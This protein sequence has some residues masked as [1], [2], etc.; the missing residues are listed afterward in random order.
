MFNRGYRG[1]G[2]VTAVST[3]M[4]LDTPFNLKRL[5]RSEKMVGEKCEWRKAK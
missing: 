4:A 5:A 3:D 2:P 1:I